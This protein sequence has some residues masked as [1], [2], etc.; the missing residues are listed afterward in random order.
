MRAALVLVPLI[1]VSSLAIAADPKAKPSNRSIK[2][3]PPPTAFATAS[4]QAASI[5]KQREAVAK[6]QVVLGIPPPENPFFVLPG[7]LNPTADNPFFILS[8]R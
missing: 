8:E 6:Q 7:T 2:E 3:E 1:A 5:R 4:A